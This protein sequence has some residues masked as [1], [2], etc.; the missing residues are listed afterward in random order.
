MAVQRSSHFAGPMALPIKLQSEGRHAPSTFCS[1]VPYT[2]T[3][4]PNRRMGMF[5]REWKKGGQGDSRVSRDFLR[6]LLGHGLRLG[7]LRGYG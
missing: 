3:H 1:H 5:H 2:N 7:V 4:S 6:H